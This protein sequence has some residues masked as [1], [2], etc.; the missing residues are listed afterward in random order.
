MGATRERRAAS[1]RGNGA[2][3]SSSIYNSRPNAWLHRCGQLRRFWHWPPSHS[4]QQIAF[5]LSSSSGTK[6]V[7][8]NRN[9]TQTQIK[10]QDWMMPARA[11]TQQSGSGVAVLRWLPI[12]TQCHKVSQLPTSRVPRFPPSSPSHWCHTDTS[13]ILISCPPCRSW[14]TR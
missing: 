10:T 14:I 12:L 11:N 4:P 6:R 1:V 9:E 13:F 2:M 5:H 7:Q 8:G 3:S